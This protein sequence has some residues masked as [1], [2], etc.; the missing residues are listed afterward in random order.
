MARALGGTN[1]QG[2]WGDHGTGPRARDQWTEP[3]GPGTNGQLA[4]G[5][6]PMDRAHGGTNGQGPGPL[7]KAQGPGPM[8][9][10]QGPGPMDKIGEKAPSSDYFSYFVGGPSGL[11]GHKL[12]LIHI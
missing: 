6:G 4:Q 2:P 1:G 9:R 8:D 12:S 7:D 11:L 3:P 5:P 10:A